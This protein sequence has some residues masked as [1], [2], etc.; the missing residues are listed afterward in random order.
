[1]TSRRETV[2]SRAHTEA[3]RKAATG[4]IESTHLKKPTPTSTEGAPRDVPPGTQERVYQSQTTSQRETV[5]S[6]AHTEASR[7]AATGEIESTYLS[8]EAYVSSTEGAPRNALI[9]STRAAWIRARPTEDKGKTSR[10]RDVR[11]GFSSPPIHA[12]PIGPV[13]YESRL[14]L[15]IKIH[16]SRS[17]SI[18][19]I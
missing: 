17:P 15:G 1:M 14:F 18:S 3:S 16:I 5:L 8:Q 10:T 4:E 12:E 7:K 9:R 6:R 13:L 11:D 19:G 2:L